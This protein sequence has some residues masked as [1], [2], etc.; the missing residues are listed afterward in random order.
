M[1]KQTA[2]QA[3]T[4][5]GFVPDEDLEEDG[6]IEE[7]P[8]STGDWLLQNVA[9]PV[10]ATPLDIVTGA[11]QGGIDLA[12]L[13]PG[14]HMQ[15]GIDLAQAA[16]VGGNRGDALIQ[17]L[18]SYIPTLV[19]SEA[20]LPLK[21]I[22]GFAPLM[23]KLGAEGATYQ[24]SQTPNEPG[25]IALSTALS[26]GIPASMVGVG[27]GFNK[28]AEF[29][30]APGVAQNIMSPI[31]ALKNLKN[32]NAVGDVQAN[33]AKNQAAEDGIWNSVTKE[34][35]AYGDKKLDTSNYVDPIKQK[36]Q[37]Y[38]DLSSKHSGFKN[39]YEGAID[40][41]KG[42]LND[43]FST[44]PAALKQNVAI[45][46]D[47]KNTL[48][49][50][51]GM[52]KTTTELEATNFAR[53]Q[54]HNMLADNFQKYGLTDT[55][56]RDWGYARNLTRDNNN[57]F[58]TV[59]DVKGNPKVSDFYAQQVTTNPYSDPTGFVNQYIPKG[60]GEGTES[61]EQFSAMVGNKDR[62][63]DYLKSNIFHDAISGE[64]PN[65]SKFVE[66]AKGLSPDQIGYLFKPQEQEQIKLLSKLNDKYPTQIPDAWKTIAG[67]A[68]AGL[69]GLSAHPVAGALA[70]A[71]PAAYQLA[72]RGASSP[73]AS[74]LI[75]NSMLARMQPGNPIVGQTPVNLSR[76]LIAANQSGGAK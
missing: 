61:M 42:Y 53:E 33:F 68:L 21:S 29:F 30:G 28:A 12:N 5:D 44:F 13:I 9:K 1:A 2:M 60:K 59:P 26:M 51:S 72:Y 15:P 64:E 10:A 31:A 71:A 75:K 62:A 66:K 43:D 58:K 22:E 54:L 45:N 63:T 46:K 40:T 52:P 35:E 24:T 32:S 25:K 36:I 14:V 38:E 7:T 37:E 11:V 4:N 17:N 74:N 6:F 19:G 50:V 23:G 56:G 18:S 27:G 69:V 47:Y 76:S 49:P 48:R 3:K 20:T 8:Q 73:S 34:A 39:E 41:L 57:I 55:L 16:G 70:V 65:V 67:G